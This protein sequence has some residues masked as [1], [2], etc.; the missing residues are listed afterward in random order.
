[1]SDGGELFAVREDTTSRPT[2]EVA[3]RGYDKRQVDQYVL[4]T[5]SEIARLAAERQRA[6]GQIQDMAGQLQQVQAELTELR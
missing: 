2:F 5:D 6:F 3:L 4:R 1:M